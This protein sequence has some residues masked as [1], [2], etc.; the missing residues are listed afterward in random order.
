[1]V[2]GHHNMTVTALGRLRNRAL[3]AWPYHQSAPETTGRMESQP[4]SMCARAVCGSFVPLTSQ[5]A[6]ASPRLKRPFTPSLWQPVTTQLLRTDSDFVLSGRQ[7]STRQF[8]LRYRMSVLGVLV[9]VFFFFSNPLKGL[10][11]QGSR[12]LETFIGK[13]TAVCMAIR[14]ASSLWS[15]LNTE[16]QSANTSATENAGSCLFVCLFVWFGISPIKFQWEIYHCIWSSPTFLQYWKTHL[17]VA[18]L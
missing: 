6:A 9:L 18:F 13:Y 8:Q 15:L 12:R 16:V 3:K 1:M 4:S 7:L 14:A 2:G 17:F 11:E 5:T 10:T